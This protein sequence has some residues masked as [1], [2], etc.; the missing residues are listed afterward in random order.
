[1][2]NTTDFRAKPH[3]SVRKG[4]LSYVMPVRGGS[5]LEAK[6]GSMLQKRSPHSRTVIMMY[7]QC[8]I[9]A[10]ADKYLAPGVKFHPD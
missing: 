4:S 3:R 2:K 7:Y 5:M 8:I 6:C 1:M 10:L 9:I